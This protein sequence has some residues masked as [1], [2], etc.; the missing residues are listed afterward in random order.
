VPAWP[1]LTIPAGYFPTTSYSAATVLITGVTIQVN[2][3][4]PYQ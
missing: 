1:M 4:K 3:G 2:G